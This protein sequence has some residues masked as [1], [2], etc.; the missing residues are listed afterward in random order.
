MRSRP[1][2]SPSANSPAIGNICSTRR[3]SLRRRIRSGAARRWSGEDGYLLGIGSLFV[4]EAI[5]GSTVQGN[6]FVPIDLLEPILDDLLRFGRSRRAARPWLGMYTAEAEGRLVVGG[7]ARGAPAEAAGVQLGD[8]VLEV[9][10][11][12]ASGLADLLRK[13]WKVGAAGVEVP[14][15]VAR[16]TEVKRIR[17]RSADRHDFL[18]KPPLQ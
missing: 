5:K 18:R 3:S 4:Q 15:T 14:L 9:A 6:M 12:R 7:L 16:D 8:I 17:V 11:E 10:G 13:T 1:A 2:F